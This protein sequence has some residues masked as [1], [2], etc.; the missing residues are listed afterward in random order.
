MLLR[1]GELNNMVF[2]N[3]LSL[4]PALAS[5]HWNRPLPKTFKGNLDPNWSKK[6]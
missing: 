1:L 3:S 6:I 2:L 4:L 5:S